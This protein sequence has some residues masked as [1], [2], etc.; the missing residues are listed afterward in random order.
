MVRLRRIPIGKHNAL[1]L[2][3]ERKKVKT[4]VRQETVDFGIVTQCGRHWAFV[5]TERSGAE[6][7]LYWSNLRLVESL[8]GGILFSTGKSPTVR[9]GDGVAFVPQKM[10]LWLWALRAD[11]ETSRDFL[12]RNQVHAAPALPVAPLPP[13][14]TAPVIN[15]EQEMAALGSERLRKWRQR[16]SQSQKAFA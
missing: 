15:L 13:T 4:M 16:Y 5:K 7:R 9:R 14:P 10:G 6:V 12:A 1:T 11:F 8:S 3:F 2:F